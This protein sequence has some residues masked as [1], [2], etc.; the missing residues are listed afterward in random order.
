MIKAA[1]LIKTVTNLGPCYENLVRE[2]VVNI[3]AECVVEG[4]EDYGKVTIRKGLVQFS[5][6]II[7]KFLGRNE[8][9]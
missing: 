5:P 9:P 6:P 3:S 4:S 1:G 7:N 8:N 2:F